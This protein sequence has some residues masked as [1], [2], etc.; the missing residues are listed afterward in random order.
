MVCCSGV[1]NSGSLRVIQNG[2]DF[3]EEVIIPINGVQKIWSLNLNEM[4][5]KINNDK[6]MVLSM[7]NCTRI[8]YHKY[9]DSWGLTEGNTFNF[10]DLDQPTIALS[11]LGN[12]CILQITPLQ[13]RLTRPTDN[14]VDILW[15]PIQGTTIHSAVMGRDYIV[16]ACSRG[17]LVIFEFSSSNGRFIQA[18]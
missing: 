12:G 9:N 6:L 16:I 3:N 18:R 10:I 17:R 11:Y 15:T 14:K 2:Y 4:D 13:I 1:N 8:L 7:I 5:P